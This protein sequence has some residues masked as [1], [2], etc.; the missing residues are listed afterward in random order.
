MT[1]PFFTGSTGADVSNFNRA[2]DSLTASAGSKISR[3]ELIWASI[4]AMARSLNDGHTSYAS[5]SFWRLTERSGSTDVPDLGYRYVN[6]PLG[7][8]VWEIIPF[9][10]AAKAGLKPGDIVTAVNDLPIY[11]TAPLP[12]PKTGEAFHLTVLRS[13][14]ELKLDLTP[15]HLG[16]RLTT[17]MLDNKVAYVRFYSFLTSPESFQK[18]FGPELRAIADQSPSAWVIDLRGN[19]G[20]RL[21]LATYF[22]RLLGLEGDL[23][24][25][26]SRFNW[27]GP[28]TPKVGSIVKGKPMVI[29]VNEL[30]FSASE[31]LAAALQD[32]G[33]AWIVGAKTRGSANS[34]FD[35]AVAGGG[36]SI[37]AER[38]FVAGSHRRVDGIGVTPDDIARLTPEM[39]AAGHDLQMERALAYIG[40]AEQKNA[41]R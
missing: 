31:L 19:A 18:D 26:E 6:D 13:G 27:S 30:S 21:D 15:E 32:S 35:R 23:V 34:S 25:R 14:K 7:S 10:G 33:Q 17:Q 22:A 36:L 3:D 39:L 5:P 16:R 9:G 11:G 12:L 20:G 2:F 37:T 28:A 40:A 41:S 8:L 38:N 1:R 29:L 4:S 24:T